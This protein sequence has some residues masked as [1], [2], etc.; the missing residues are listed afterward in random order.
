MAMI[1]WGTAPAVFGWIYPEHRDIALIAVQGL[2]T[3]RRAVFDRLWQDARTGNETR[4]CALGA[5][6]HQGLTPPCI[7]WAAL[8]AIAG[9]HSCSSA[10]ML[11]TVCKSDW[12]LVVASVAAQ[13]KEE[14]AKIEVTALPEQT[15]DAATPLVDARRRLADE[16]I[17]AKR[18]NALRTADTQLQRADA[19]YVT[20]ADKNLAHFL[21]PRP[22]TKLDLFEYAQLAMRPGTV[23]NAFGVYAWYHVSAL[24]KASRLAHESLSPE[25][26]RALSRAA[27]FDEAFALHFLQDMYA[28]GHLAGSWGNTAQRK[29][30]HDYYNQHGLEV[31]TWKGRDRTIV[32]MGDA[33]MRPDDAALTANAVRISLEQILDAASG[34][35][36]VYKMPH[37]ATAVA[38][39]ED[40]A[41][42]GNPTFPDRA[43]RFGPGLT[44]YRA[45]L[46]ETLLSTPVPG[47]GQG[48]GAQP[49]SRSEV[50]MFLGLAGAIDGR[51]VSGG[52]EASENGEGFIG[53]LDLSLRVGLG[54][55]GAL[56]DTDDGLAFVQIGF[57]ADGPSTN[58]FVPSGLGALE[59]NLTASI[60]AR[61]GLSTRIR[62]PY[63]LIPGDLLLLS[64][65]YWWKPQTYT[66]IATTA[67][68]GGL[69]GLQDGYAT[70]LGRFQFVLGRELG[71]TLFGLG[72]VHQAFIPA[73][74][75]GGPTR[76][77]EYKSVYFDAPI[78]EYR[79]FR[80]YSANQS[81]SVTVQLFGGAD[82]PY[83]QEIKAPPGAA[84]ADLRTVWM[85]GLRLVFDWRYYW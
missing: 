74:Q 37:A 44:H 54:L 70:G 58:K 24:Q 20:R 36:R 28:A 4:L 85:I 42:C 47:L 3:E 22:D 65:M 18:L 43:H 8:S 79:P 80:A 48:L 83:D 13:L 31:F 60:P 84:P 56:G 12:I 7:D 53:G 55:E 69:L 62:V 16:A 59:G 41:I 57:R 30:T 32:L 81:S 46:E 66:R 50:G 1:V 49:R 9:D 19:Q 35:S 15:R 63:Y 29:G 68:S 14:L 10:D 71:V 75:P 64:P 27:L 78:V 72:Q 52:F 45:P 34:R 39:P 77:I 17:R 82:I 23:V 11:E 76:V 33:H 67:A 40:F 26:R 61:S 51:G 38:R 25:E 73:E 21:L 6:E 2:D 5:D